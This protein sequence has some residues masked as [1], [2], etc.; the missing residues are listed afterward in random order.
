M[1]YSD[2]MRQFT[3]YGKGGIYKSTATQ[4]TVVSQA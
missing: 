2:L 4:N 1:Y 3:I